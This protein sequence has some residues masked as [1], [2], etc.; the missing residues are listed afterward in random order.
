M[1]DDGASLTEAQVERNAIVAMILQRSREALASMQRA[2]E[3]D[4]HAQAGAYHQIA[5]AMLDLHAQVLRRE[6]PKPEGGG[7]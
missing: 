1:S 2:S 6:H 3:R 5:R 7:G 4:E